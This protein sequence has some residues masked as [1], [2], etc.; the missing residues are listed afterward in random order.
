MIEYSF[1]YKA[2]GQQLWYIQFSLAFFRIYFY[3]KVTI[4][5]NRITPRRNR[6][7][8]LDLDFAMK[9]DWKKYLSTNCSNVNLLHL[10]AYSKTV[11]LT[12]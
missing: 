3:T 11:T 6:I 2:N 7:T 1:C 10:F 5:D 9:I 4:I 12:V 8:P